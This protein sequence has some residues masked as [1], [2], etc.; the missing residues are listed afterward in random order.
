MRASSRRAVL[1]AGAER[2]DSWA[3]DAHKWLNTPY[4]CGI[5][6]VADRTVLAAAV[7]VRAAYLPPVGEVDDPTDR[8][9]E[10]RAALEGAGVGGA[11]VAR[12][13]G[14]GTTRRWCC[15]AAEA[16]AAAIESI[17][18]LR[19]RG[20]GIN[21]VVVEAVDAGE[22]DPRAPVPFWLPW[23]P[24]DVA[25]R[26]ARCGR[27][28]RGSGCRSRTGALISTMSPRSPPPLP[29]RCARLAALSSGPIDGTRYHRLMS[30]QVPV[31]L[32]PEVVRGYGQ[33]AYAVVSDPAGPPRVTHVMPT[34]SGETLTFGL[35]RTS[36]ALLEDNL[37]SVCSGRPRTPRR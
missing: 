26:A 2:A 11:A 16:L 37:T 33:S 15:N 10:F 19:V 35:G 29:T 22:S 4:D 24:M 7:G 8:V 34:F 31:E 18:G 30:M 20:Q 36:C 25:I 5:S 6:I 9:L 23:W 28:D 3:C 13:L 14:G 12:P 27:A 1:A 32:L 21:Q 17:D